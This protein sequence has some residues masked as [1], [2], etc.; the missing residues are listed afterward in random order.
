M[1]KDFVSIVIPCLNEEKTIAYCIKKAFIG[2]KNSQLDG[3]VIVSDN[4]SS[5][6]SVQ[7]ALDEGARVV[8]VQKKGYGSALIGGI[9]EAKGSFIIMGDAD[10][11]YNF[12]HADR[13]IEG[14]KKGSD[15]VVGNRFRGGIEKNAMPFLHRTIGNPGLSYLA[16][17]L[18]NFDVGDIY[19]GLRGFTKKAYIKMNLKATGMEF[20]TEMIVKSSLLKLKITE[21]PTTLSKS[22]APRTPHL[23]TFRDGLRTL[24]LFF[25]YSFIKFFNLSFN[26]VLLIFLPLYVSVLI[27][28]PIN[29]QGITFSSGTVNSLE[30]IVL[31]IL[32]LKSMLK[33]S[34]SLFPNFIE[35]KHRTVKPKN[36]GF[37]YLTFGFILFIIALTNWAKLNFGVLDDSFNLKLISVGSLLLTYGIFEV[38]RL[39]IETSTDYFKNLN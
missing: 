10:S 12:E 22:I 35:N 39:F 28:S 24:K 21:V 11:T 7:I 19:C 4:G 6:N 8:K 34:F 16:K 38:F 15:L 31:T 36:Y 32:I 25:S 26:F 18:F 13:F 3:E 29:F 5:D 23:N 9:E 20:A 33:V 17:K 27:L 30:N 37:L 2:I 1:N 14:L